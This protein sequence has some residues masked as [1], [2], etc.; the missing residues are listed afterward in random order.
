MGSPSLFGKLA[1]FG[2]T[3]RKPMLIPFGLFSPNDNISFLPDLPGVSQAFTPTLTAPDGTR[4]TFQ[5]AGLPAYLVWN[6]VDQFQNTGYTITGPVSGIYTATFTD[7]QGNVLTPSPTDDIRAAGSTI[8]PAAS[9]PGQLSQA[10]V[11]YAST[12]NINVTAAQE[13]SILLTGNVAVTN[14]QYPFSSIPQGQWVILR[15]QQNAT[16]GW[17]VALPTNLVTDPGFAVD[18]TPSRTTVLPVSWNGV[19]WIFFAVPFTV[20]GL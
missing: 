12:L 20:A 5:F 9:A 6:G 11:A 18:P 3:L 1:N 15:F 19:S 8:V 10:N 16:G 4:T 2:A 7:Y 14:L 17:T 13:I